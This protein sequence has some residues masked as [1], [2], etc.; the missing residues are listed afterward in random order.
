MSELN[1]W[2]HTLNVGFRTRIS[3]ETDFPCIYG[4][5]VGLGRS[6]VK[7]D[8]ELT[9]DKWCR[10]IQ[11]GRNYIGDGR[12]H[13][14]DFSID[15]TELGSDDSTVKLAQPGRVSIRAK[16]AALLAQSRSIKIGPFN[17]KPYWH[18]ERARLG[19][20]RKVPVEVIVNGLPVSQTTI[21]ADGT[22]IDF[23]TEIEIEKSSWIA[24]RILGSSHTNPIWVIVGDQPVRASRQSAEWCLKSVDQC[25]SQK[26]RFIKADE[27]EQAKADYQHARDVYR[28]RIEES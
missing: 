17:E 24:L 20:S 21:D 13:L 7:V 14:I 28:R 8:G 23:A 18:I 3:G 5:R 16:V 6:Y 19:N 25:W 26:Q 15:G 2:Y 27:M 4:E 1:I 10:G 9:Y 22:M 12:S 11:A